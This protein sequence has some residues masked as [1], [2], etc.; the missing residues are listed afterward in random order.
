MRR[1]MELAADLKMTTLAAQ[2]ES[3]LLKLRCRW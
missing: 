3:E 2:A 1:A